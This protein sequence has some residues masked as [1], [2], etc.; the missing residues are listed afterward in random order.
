MSED[1][2]EAEVLVYHEL[3]RHRQ[4][5]ICRFFFLPLALF[6]LR[7][8]FPRLPTKRVKYVDIFVIVIVVVV[9]IVVFVVFVVVVVGLTLRPILSGRKQLSLPEHA[10][11]TSSFSRRT[12]MQAVFSS[13][14]PRARFE[15]E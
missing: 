11:R 10:R 9:V 5:L 15:R 8:R 3:D 12:R 2:D 13:L 7:F 4:K 1:V 6:R 14:A